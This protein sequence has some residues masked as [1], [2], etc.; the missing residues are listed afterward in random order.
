MN[1][2]K[3]T[4][5]RN[6]KFG[7]VWLVIAGFFGF[8]FASMML[9][10][11]SYSSDFA[12]AQ[13]MEDRSDTGNKVGK[14]DSSANLALR[15]PSYAQRIIPKTSA[16]RCK[17]ELEDEWHMSQSEEDKTLLQWFGNVCGGKYLE[18]G[19]LDG[20]RYSNTYVFNKGLDWKGVLVEAS[21]QNYENLKL[22]RPN[23]IATVHGGVCREEQ[24]LHWV[25]G[26]GGA[27]PVGGFLEFAAE[28]FQKRWWTPE[29]IANAVV[30]KCRTLS[31]ILLDVVGKKA[32]FDFYSLDIEGAEFS[33]LQSLDFD[34]YEFGII[35]AE[36]DESNQK[37]NMALRT[38]VE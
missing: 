11:A 8:M 29:A 33:A 10:P 1:I 20:K 3:N 2:T 32:F 26:S 31:N 30:V 23:E 9:S 17:R 18:M 13:A 6:Q 27:S 4:K 7:V 22:N 21:P 5:P 15:R 28:D 12:I 14:D 24:D 19:G 38:L 25:S 34:R 35:F 16:K 37:K 36:A